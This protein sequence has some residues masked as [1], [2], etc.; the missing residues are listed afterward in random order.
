MGGKTVDCVR[1]RKPD[2][3]PAKKAP[4]V[5]KLL[6]KAPKTTV[7]ADLNDDIPY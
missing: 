3:A 2:A 1:I 4:K 6:P 5:T 7:A